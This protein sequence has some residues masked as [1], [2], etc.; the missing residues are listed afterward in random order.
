[1]NEKQLFHGTIKHSVGAFV[2][3]SLIGVFQS[4]MEMIMAEEFISPKM[5]QI[6]NITQ[7]QVSIINA[8][9]FWPGYRLVRTPSAIVVTLDRHL[10]IMSIPRVICTIR[11]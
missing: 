9:C 10:N 2:N 1:M 3:K 6:A 8:A 11:A 5:S 7:N 4:K